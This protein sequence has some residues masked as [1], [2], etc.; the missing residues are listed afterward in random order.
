[1]AIKNKFVTWVQKHRQPGSEKH[2]YNFMSLSGGKYKI[3][4]LEKFIHLLNRHYVKLRQKDAFPLVFRGPRQA[5]TPCY[6][7]ID[8]LLKTDV[9][10]PTSIYIQIVHEFLVHLKA[11]TGSNDVWKVI[12]SRRTG[13]Y[14]A[15]GKGFKNGFHLMLPNLFVTPDVMIEF[16]KAALADNYWLT[17]LSEFPIINSKED[18]L[19]AAITTRR[20]GLIVLGMNKWLLKKNTPCSAHY[21]CYADTWRTSWFGDETPL[22]FG[23]Q[24]QSKKHNDEYKQILK[25]T[26]SWVFKH[27]Y[28]KIVKEVPPVPP[29]N[30]G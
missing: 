19:D 1:M 20:N 4:D 11:V 21:I 28:T 25:M 16:R 9:S 18:I 7:D 6:L 22:P 24:F 26:Y 10:I 5:S 14:C 17:L 12:L 15:D 8:L 23:W 2:D 27:D 3:T 13:S 29:P 30:L